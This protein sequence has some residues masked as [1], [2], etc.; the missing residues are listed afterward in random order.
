MREQAVHIHTSL[1][2]CKVPRFLA[3]PPEIAATMA[4]LTTSTERASTVNYERKAR[5]GAVAGNNS[6]GKRHASIHAY[7]RACDLVCTTFRF[8]IV[9]AGS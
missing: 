9:D 6:N 4:P 3:V 8:S 7:D 5:M 2:T 1:R